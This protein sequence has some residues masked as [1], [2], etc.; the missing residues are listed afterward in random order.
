T[1]TPAP[2]VNFSF[3]PAPGGSV[4]VV[5]SSDFHGVDG[6]TADAGEFRIKNDTNSAETIT[7]IR[8]EASNGAMFSSMTLSAGGQSVTISDPATDN[9]FFFDPGIT[10]QPGDSVEASLSVVIGTPSTSTTSTATPETTAT[11]TTT[12]AAT[13]T[14]S[15]LGPFGTIQRPPR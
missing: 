9:S 14:E 11:G 5:S 15:D 10:I 4:A 6:D 8:V 3:T 13:A 1:V 2:T 12:P 7:E